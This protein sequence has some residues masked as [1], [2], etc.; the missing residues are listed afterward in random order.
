MMEIFE[1]LS[2]ARPFSMPT[3]SLW[4]YHREWRWRPDTMLCTMWGPFYTPWQLH[5]HLGNL[6]LVKHP[7][8]FS[9]ASWGFP[10]QDISWVVCLLH[11]RRVWLYIMVHCLMQSVNSQKNGSFPCWVSQRRNF[12]SIIVIV[13]A[14]WFSIRV[15]TLGKIGS[16]FFPPDESQ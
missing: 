11:S 8:D 7:S 3:L 5:T 9:W 2:S 4:Q 14:S 15:R 10:V 6:L 13:S 12:L 16:S 1:C